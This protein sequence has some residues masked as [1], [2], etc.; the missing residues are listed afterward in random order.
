M[1]KTNKKKLYLASPRGFCAGVERAIDVV[2]LA[3]ELYGAPIFVKHAIVH[4]THVLKRL[5]KRGAIFTNDIKSIPQNSHVVFSAH[6]SPPEHYDQARKRHLDIIDATCP[7]VTKVHFEV[8]R[9]ARLGYDIIM[10]GHKKHVEPIGTLGH[11][12]NVHTFLVDSLQDVDGID[13]PNPEHVAIVT[14]T[15]LSID[16]T[17]EILDALK[18]KFP[19]AELP[20]KQDICYAT[21]NRQAGVKALL[22]LIEALLV[23]GSETSSNSRRLVE[24]ARRRKI[25]G[26]LIEDASAL[27]AKWFEHVQ[28]LG[29]SSGASAPEDL[30]QELVQKLIGMGFELSNGKQHGGEDVFFALPVD[31]ANRAKKLQSNSHILQKHK[32]EQGRSMKV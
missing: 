10:V 20:K 19:K 14:Q 3:L 28:S 31:L 23:V 32:I 15:T 11:A 27:Q 12:K 24:T 22:P 1:K 29:V 8:K 25:P 7:L 5:E 30:V 13:V 17:A 18:K 26:Y 16:E 2:E 9:F 21:T 6:G 4:N